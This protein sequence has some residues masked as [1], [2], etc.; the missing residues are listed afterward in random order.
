MPAGLAVVAKAE[1]P[2]S[3][4]VAQTFFWWCDGAL[5]VE[6]VGI[7]VHVIRCVP[8]QWRLAAEPCQVH[9]TKV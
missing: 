2:Q 5:P 9:R 6:C 7:G 8:R 3:I 4:V 1:D